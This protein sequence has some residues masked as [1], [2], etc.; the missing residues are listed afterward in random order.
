MFEVG[1]LDGH[2]Y[3]VMAL[4]EGKTLAELIKSGKPIAA[5]NAVAAVRRIASALAKAHGKGIVHRDLKPANVMINRRGEPI[6][7]DFGLARLHKPGDARLT[8][9]GQILGSPAYMSPEQARGATDQIGP[10]SDIYSLGVILYELLC[11]RRPYLGT[12]TE[13]LGQILHVEPPPPFAA[14]GRRGPGIEAICLK[15][16][17]K[18]P[19]GRYASMR[20]FA[21]SLSEYLK[22]SAAVGR[23]RIRPTGLD[24]HAR[25]FAVERRRWRLPPAKKRAHPANRRGRGSAAHAPRAGPC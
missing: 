19:S 15:A 18:D 25:R 17:A 23:T 24:R 10:A 4:V 6:V 21:A 8:H 16:M 3:I 12:V 1:E 2:P 11:G 9:S 13:V 22:S 5:R 14:Q 20:N 7:M